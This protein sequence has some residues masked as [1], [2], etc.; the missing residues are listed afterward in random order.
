MVMDILSNVFLPNVN[1]KPYMPHVELGFHCG[2][3]NNFCIWN[4]S[5][6]IILI[7]KSDQHPGLIFIYLSIY[8]SSI[9]LVSFGEAGWP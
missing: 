8:Q 1:F 9:Y 7:F 6:I 3:A 4:C 5:F 2:I